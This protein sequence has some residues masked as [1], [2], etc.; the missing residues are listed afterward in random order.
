[1]VCRKLARLAE[2]V[3]PPRRGL[4]G[5]STVKPRSWRRPMTP[6]HDEASAQAPC[7]ST[8]VGLAPTVTVAGRAHAARD[9]KTARPATA[10]AA[11]PKIRRPLRRAMVGAD[12]EVSLFSRPP[13]CPRSP[14][15]QPCAV[16]TV[17]G[18]IPAVDSCSVNS[19]LL[20]AA[21]AVSTTCDP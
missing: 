12:M 3:A 16:H 17:A 9:G 18:E 13:G 7:S 5:A 4:G 2:S 8:I 14:E 10:A 20:T 21:G 11:A 6:L 15:R 19:L 1:M